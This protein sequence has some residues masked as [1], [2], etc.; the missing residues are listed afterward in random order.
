MYVKCLKVLVWIQA[1]PA[2]PVQQI[3]VSSPACQKT[4]MPSPVAPN[5][6]K[7]EDI[8]KKIAPPKTISHHFWALQLE[9]CDTI[10]LR[11]CTQVQHF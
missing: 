7:L 5:T 1:S 6:R 10:L 3:W 9:K 4:H 8:S 2:G 11:K